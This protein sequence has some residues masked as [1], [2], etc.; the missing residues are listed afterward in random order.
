MLSARQVGEASNN[1]LAIIHHQ[2]SEFY[3]MKIHDT[4]IKVISQSRGLSIKK[5]KYYVQ[6]SC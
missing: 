1:S 2:N 5:P 4:C 3:V 6:L